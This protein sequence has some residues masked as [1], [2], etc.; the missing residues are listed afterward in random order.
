MRNLPRRQEIT[1]DAG[2]ELHGL[3]DQ[4]LNRLPD[5]YRVPIVL[6]DLEG[7]TRKEAA[8]QLGWPEGTLSGRLSRA[9]SLL[10]RRL[11]RHGTALTAGALTAALA[12]S[13]ASAEVPRPLAVST[14]IGWL[15]HADWR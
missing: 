4:E 1:E 11:S 8:R 2:R 12:H 6:C 10:A 14:T 7:K 15:G 13:T 9:R 5:K 3:L